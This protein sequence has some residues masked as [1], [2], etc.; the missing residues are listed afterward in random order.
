MSLKLDSPP[1]KI[2]LSETLS[3]SK[4]KK[5]NGYSILQVTQPKIFGIIFDSSHFFL[6]FIF[7]SY[8]NMTTHFQEA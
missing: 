8:D 4:K 1:I 2:L 6:L 3:L 7:F 5:K